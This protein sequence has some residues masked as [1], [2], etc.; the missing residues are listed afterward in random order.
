MKSILVIGETCQDNFV[1]CDA[2]RL[3]PDLPVPVLE[4]NRQVQNP[5]MAMNVQ[6]NILQFEKN[7]DL[8]TNPD[9]ETMTKTRYVHE[10]TNHTFLRIDTPHVVQ[11]LTEEQISL[12]Y[13]VIVISDY[14]KGFLSEALIEYIG[15]NHKLVFLDTKKKLGSWSSW[16]TYIKINHY[17]Y[18][19][20]LPLRDTELEKKIIH[21]NGENGCSFNGRIYPVK[22]VEVKDS[23]GAGDA[24]LAALVV[25]YV[26][27][28]DIEKSITFANECASQV[29]QHR[30]VSII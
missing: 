8:L 17:E 10:S 3:A 14:N 5:G 18:E 13:D 29:V 12:D 20:S 4:I 9:W 19:R 30:G 2:K 24:F 1:Y 22:K 21:T 26:K 7:C 11:P 6:R 27:S 15:R 28:E 25:E 16:C 23:S